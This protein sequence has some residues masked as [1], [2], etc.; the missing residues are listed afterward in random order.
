MWVGVSRC[1]Y[2]WVSVWVWWSVYCSGTLLLAARTP[3]YPHPHTPFENSR[4]EY[5]KIRKLEFRIME[6]SKAWI[7]KVWNSKL[8]S[9]KIF[10]ESNRVFVLYTTV[11]SNGKVRGSL[12]TVTEELPLLGNVMVTH[13]PYSLILIFYDLF[14]IR[15]PISIPF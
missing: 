13:L 8:G 2:G 7:E 4:I 11:M 15:S 10:F 1:G 3:T 6:N 9:S 5:F 12:V 14:I